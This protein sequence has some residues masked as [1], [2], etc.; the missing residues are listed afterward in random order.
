MDKDIEERTKGQG[1]QVRQVTENDRIELQLDRIKDK[2]KAN[3]Y[4]IWHSVVIL[5][6]CTPPSL[7]FGHVGM[8][9][10]MSHF[11][12]GIFPTMSEFFPI[13]IL[14]AWK[15]P[16]FVDGRIRAY[17]MQKNA[18]GGSKNIPLTAEGIIRRM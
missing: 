8:F 15:N 2:D 18:V 3:D 17:L 5:P 14:Y 13:P 9:P 11:Q 6:S 1:Y 16:S 7:L 12:G 4:L 10:T